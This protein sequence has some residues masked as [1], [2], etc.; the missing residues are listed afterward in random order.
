[1]VGSAPRVGPLRLA[2]G[3][4]LVSLSTAGVPGMRRS[5]VLSA[6]QALELAFPDTAAS[7]LLA[8]TADPALSSPSSLSDEAGP[9]ADHTLETLGYVL[10][11]VGL[12]LGGFGV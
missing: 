7:P 1:L 10:A 6:G 12:G 4:H 11:G 2:A 3:S 9:G 5:V 8:R